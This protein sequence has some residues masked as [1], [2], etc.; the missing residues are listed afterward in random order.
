[1]YLQLFRLMKKDISEGIYKPGDKLPSKRT[2]ALDTGTSLITVEHTYAMLTDEGYIEPRERSGY[3]V[4]QSESAAAEHRELEI[5]D[6]P[7]AHVADTSL[8]FPVFSRT[9]RKVLSEYGERITEKSPNFGCPE[10][11]SAVAGYLRRSRGID[12][13]PSQIMIGAGSEYL[14]TLMIRTLGPDTVFGIESPC[15]D[16]IRK[17][18]MSSNVAVDHL[19]MGRDGI[20][21][22]ELSRT[23]ASVLH[24]TP[25]N[26][27][28]TAVTA[29]APK[30][31]EYVRWVQA[32]PE[33]YIIEDDYD[34]EFSSVTKA[35]STL[36]S[37]DNSGSVIY[38]NTFSRTLFPGLRAGYAVLPEKLLD[39]YAEQNGFLS[40][41]VPMLTQYC[42]AELLSNGEFQRHINRVRRK[43]KVQGD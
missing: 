2:L 40:C 38:M 10:L 35:E 34:S 15:Y 42:I 26:S 6:R 25:Y 30:R 27:V 19:R 8:P 9:V 13:S 22:E 43:R 32:V 5:R 24:L 3:F 7:A 17:I 20:L 37:M 28:P 14:Y 33:R 18:Y 11:R 16:T 1:M 23:D 31:R 39:K 41:S 36:Y 12:V 21:P 4:V 29:S